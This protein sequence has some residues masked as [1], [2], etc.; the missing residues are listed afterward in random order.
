MEKQFGTWVKARYGTE[1]A[2]TSAWGTFRRP[3]DNWAAGTF[4]IMAAYNL[5]ANGPLYEYA[6][7]TARA[8]DFVQFLAETQRTYYEQRQAQLR[9]IGY[10]GVTVSTAWFS[11]GAASDS[12]N[13]WTDDAMDAIDRHGY[14]GG[15][16]GVHRIAPGAVSDFTHMAS[17]FSGV[18][19]AGAW[20]VED[21]PFIMTEWAQVS[22]NQWRAESMPLMAFYGMGLQGWDASYAFSI[23]DTAFMRSGWADLSAYFTD[24]PLVM[25]QFPALALAVQRGDFAEGGAISQRRISLDDAFSG[26]DARQQAANATPSEWYAVGRVSTKVGDGLGSSVKGDVS[27]YWDVTGK[28]VTSNTGQ[29]VWDYGNQVVE[30]R[31]DR[32]QGVIGFAGGQSYDLPGLTVSVDTGFVSLLFTSLDGLPILNSTHILVTALARDKQVGAR[33]SEDGKTLIS[34]GSDPLMLE[35]V[36]AT[37][38]MKGGALSGVRAVDVYGVPTKKAVPLSGNTFTIDG[39]YQSFYYEI[40][41]PAGAAAT[42]AAGIASG[43]AFA[44]TLA[45]SVEEEAAS[46][47]TLTSVGV[48]RQAGAT[49]AMAVMIPM[50]LPGTVSGEK[51]KEEP[52][53]ERARRG[54]ILPG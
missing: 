16:V 25:G 27:G 39:R 21:K 4:E 40:K 45:A 41:R 30:A 23:G 29:L 48:P 10:Q 51:E 36:K 5:G 54:G 37:I 13:L 31:S 26:T 44:E 43:E 24:T 53:R 50:E 14:A 3:R 46:A 18:L 19:G 49:G 2:L 35:P 34:V 8:G 7:Q 15:G 6:G 11:G 1:A 12:A 9:S 38:T 33:Y 28:V 20:Q 22:P 32:T 17:P 52:L 42:A 47:A